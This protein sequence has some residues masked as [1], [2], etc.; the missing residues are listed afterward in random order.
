MKRL[1]VALLGCTGLAAPAFAQDAPASSSATASAAENELIVVTGSRIKRSIADSPVPLTIISTD[2][3]R[4]EGIATPEQ[5]ISYL[6]SNGNGLDNLAS[7]ADVVSGAAR[8]NNGASAANLRGQGAS[9]TLILLNGRRV[10]AHGLNGGV[11]D[12]NQI[13]MSVVERVEVLKDGASAIYGTDAVGGVINFITY[14]DF[15]GVKASGFMDVTEAGGGNLWRFSFLAGHGDLDKDRFNVTFGASITD[16][17]M[18]RGDQRDFVNTFQPDRGLSVDTRGTPFAT[19]FP[20]GVSPNSPLGTI[21]NSAATAPFLPGSTTVRAGGGINPLDL[22]G[23]LGCDSIDGMG[24]Y[25]ELL[26][27]VPTAKYACAWDTGRAAVLQQPIRTISYYGA[28]TGQFGSHQVRFELTGSQADSKKLFSN[29]QLSSSASAAAT[30]LNYVYSRNAASAATYDRVFNQLV[31]VFPTLEANRGL[32]M[33]L[34]WRCMECGPREIETSTDTM[35]LALT[36]DGPIAGAWEYHVGASYGKSEASSTLGKGYFYT[37]T[38]RDS[39]GNILVNGMVDAL[40]TGV[41]NPFLL[42]GESQSAEAMALIAATSAEGVTLY[43]GKYGLWQVDGSAT[44]PLFDIWGGTVQAAVGLD[45][46]RET[47]SFNG[48]QREAATRP[49]IFNA[50]FDDAN[51]LDSRNRDVK[52]AY[53]EVMFPIFTG[54]E[55]TGAFRI[56]DYTGFGTTTNPKI[57]ARYRP[58]DQLMF[59]GSYNTSFRVPTFNQLYNGVLESPYSGRDIYDPAT[60]SAGRVDTTI[61]GCEAINPTILTGGRPNL[62]P[63][64]ADQFSAGVVFEPRPNIMLSADWWYIKREGKIDVLQLQDMVANYDIFSDRF[65]RDSTG[66]IVTIDR[67]WVNSGETETSGI[68]F[69]ARAGTPLFAGDLSFGFDGSLLLKK[70]SRLVPGAPQG[71]SEVGRFTFSGDLGVKWKHN[72]FLTYAQGPW[73]ASISQLYRSGYKNQELPG[74]TSGRVDPP[75]LYVNVKPYMLHN[76]TVGYEVNDRWRV[77]GGIK[78]LFD[79]DPPFA[80]T[81]DSNSGAGS[82]WEPRV[83]DPRGR[84]YTLTLEMQM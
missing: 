39:N 74:V 41:I 53:V 76:L 6:T 71:A 64:T 83:A 48:D 19:I 5:F 52:A 15:Q 56:D 80:I 26:W 4:R 17:K 59:R 55:L 82:S 21:I 13:P 60:C 7:N 72:I 30:A 11:V 75:N 54:F 58:V 35:R 47:Y 69:A 63:E 44:G 28:A 43:G 24:S 65:I 16:A 81:Y 8:G 78:N 32:P 70:R 45:W 1:V 29:N 36:A 67:T 37:R 34:R 25:D 84:S 73:T 62:G 33:A 57:T 40:M 9:A 3:L 23:N 10:P 18:L 20:L 51:A 42:P 50:P 31:S 27:D 68:E 12:I 22:P 38:V 46:R 14:Q 61:P 2:D 77:T 66:Q 79:K 49:H